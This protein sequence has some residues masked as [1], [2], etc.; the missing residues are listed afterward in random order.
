MSTFPQNPFEIL[1]PNV[2][3]ALSQEELKEKAYEQLLP[4]L[5]HKIRV[6]V[7]EWRER[8]YKGASD[9][10]KALLNFWFNTEHKD[11]GTFFRY[12]FAQREAI[13]S[14]IYVYE[15][16]RARDK[17]ELM[18]FDSSGRISTAVQDKGSARIKNF[19]SL[20]K[21]KPLV[22]NN[23]SYLVRKRVFLLKSLATINSNLNLPRFLKI[24]QTLFPLVKIIQ[25]LILK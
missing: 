23:Q 2:R 20:R 18:R 13:E 14:I 10:T 9:T 19:I 12:Y 17:Y 8:D 6:A 15:V 7:N 21:A 11:N 24:V 3:W 1:N 16:A 4:P 25:H 5:V 22:A